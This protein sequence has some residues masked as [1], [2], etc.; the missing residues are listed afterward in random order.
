MIDREWLLCM[1]F[2]LI[3][4]EHEL[5]CS[6]YM[7]LY[8]QRIESHNERFILY[9]TTT[10][11][12]YIYIYQ[13]LPSIYNVISQ[14]LNS[15]LQ[16]ANEKTYRFDFVDSHL[17]TKMSKFNWT[18]NWLQKRQE[19]LLPG[20]R[21]CTAQWLETVFV[22]VY[23]LRYYINRCKPMYINISHICKPYKSLII[24]NPSP[25]TNDTTSTSLPPLKVQPAAEPWFPPFATRG[26]G[27]RS[28][29]SFT[30]AAHGGRDQTPVELGISQGT[31]GY[32]PVRA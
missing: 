7:L 8:V 24:L 20:T 29:G 23:I 3:C 5:R 14:S 12:V 31:Q 27:S 19:I 32:L 26:S 25:S 6:Y 28:G 22:Y 18:S 2:C 1:V 30:C 13:S 10:Y 16:P 17:L 4:L 9:Y 11:Y 21:T 15:K